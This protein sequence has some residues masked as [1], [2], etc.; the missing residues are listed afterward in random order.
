MEISMRNV[1]TPPRYREPPHADEHAHT[2]VFIYNAG[3]EVNALKMEQG[4]K[5][6]REDGTHTRARTMHGRLLA[7][8]VVR[9]QVRVHDSEGCAPY[10]HTETLINA[11]R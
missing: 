5:G 3:R 9:E 10:V 6:A 4:G 8:A 1:H 11:Y 7:V 2:Y